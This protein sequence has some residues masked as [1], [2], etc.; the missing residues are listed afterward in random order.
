MFLTS[1]ESSYIIGEL[2]VD[3]GMIQVCGGLVTGMPVSVVIF[4]ATLLVT[5]TAR[6]V[7]LR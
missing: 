5:G 4:L 6:H 3:S 2:F 1:D 7:R